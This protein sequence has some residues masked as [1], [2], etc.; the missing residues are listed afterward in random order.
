MVGKRLI[1]GILVIILLLTGCAQPPS[2][3]PT[4]PSISMTL[5]ESTEHGFSIECPEGWIESSQGSGTQFSIDFQDSEGHLTAS[6]YLQYECQ[7]ITRA[8]FVSEGKAYMESMPQYRLI[9]E[10][11]LPVG[12]GI[13]GYE[14]VASGDFG[15]GTVEKFRF[16]LLVRGKQGVWVGVRG[17]PT[18]FDEHEQIVDAV[19]DSFRLLPDYTFMAPEPWPGGTYTGSGFTIDFPEGWCQYPPLRPEHVLYFAAPQQNPSVH[20]SIQQVAEDATLADYVGSILEGIPG[21]GY[22][23]NFNLLSQTGVTLDD[24]TAAYE[25]VFTGISNLSPGY[26]SK[27]KYLIVLQ[28]EQAFWIMAASDPALFQQHEP[29]I[30]QVIYSFHPR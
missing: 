11:D 8:D 20:I 13:S 5:Y 21:S 3:T 2:E 22:W 4:P 1:F 18:D 7:E 9:S 12:E 17:T 30:N 26:T 15:T 10:R 28:G 24:G 25:F 29:A 6:V 23:T 19:V 16:V 27:C 14:I